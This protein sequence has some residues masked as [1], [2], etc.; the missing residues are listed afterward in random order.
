[1]SGSFVNLL[2]NLLHS[3]ISSILLIPWSFH[4]IVPPA[5]YRLSISG[6]TLLPPPE[7]GVHGCIKSLF[8]WHHPGMTFL[9]SVPFCLLHPGPLVT[10]KFTDLTD[11]SAWWESPFYAHHLFTINSWG[12]QACGLDGGL[13]NFREFNICFSWGPRFPRMSCCARLHEEWR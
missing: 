8:T 1:M 6:H 7:S 5:L 2:A 4:H 13:F 9:C 11:T 3:S 12:V 10:S